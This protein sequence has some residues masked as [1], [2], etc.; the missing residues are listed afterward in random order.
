MFIQGPRVWGLQSW[1]VERDRFSRVGGLAQEVVTSQVILGE[2]DEGVWGRL[3][4]FG[5]DLWVEV[6]AQLLN[7][8][9]VL[10]S[11]RGD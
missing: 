4:S 1:E 2:L 6:L 11:G 10:S 5:E 9:C 8:Y 7:P 3:G